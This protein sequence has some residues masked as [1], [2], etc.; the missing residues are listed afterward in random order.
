[1]H[2]D[3]LQFFGRLH[4]LWVH[5]PI[6]FVL[7]AA[8]LQVISFY[9]KSPLLGTAIDIALLTGAIAALGSV[10][11]GLFLS[12]SGG[13]NADTLSW[14][15]WIGIAVTILLFLTW[16]IRRKATSR[17]ILKI[18]LSNWLL[19]ICI[20]L[21]TIGGHLGGKMTHGDGYL[22]DNLPPFLQS[23]FGSGKKTIT[24]KAIAELDSV[25]VY[26]D[27]I[28]PIF[29]KHCISCHNTDKKKGE[30]ILSDKE[31]IRQGGKSGNTIVAGNIEKSELFHRITLSPNNS[32]FMPAGSNNPLT[33]VEVFLIRDWINSGADYEKN[34]TTAGLDE[35][36]KFLVAAYLGIDTEKGKEIKLPAAPA[37]DSTVLT[38]LRNAGLIIKAL[39]T[40]S[41]LLEVSFVM[42]QQR[43]QTEIISLLGKLQAIKQ[44][45]YRL[46]LSNCNLS[47]ESIKIISGFTALN[48]LELQKTNL[49]DGATA[50]LS[51]LQQLETV[52]AGQNSLTD[53]SIAAFKKMA[54][55]KK[56][57]LWQT[58]ISDAGYKDLQS[59]NNGLVIER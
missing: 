20:L 3:W 56:I 55:L 35:K 2:T 19:I 14:H 46:D 47:A 32:K 11:S 39:A 8:V 6:G 43:S 10:L 54:G 23:L 17:A 49:T 29:D 5:L 36:T 37:V 41:N 45:V 18:S 33:P 9:K 4:P 34:I 15:K 28:Q 30:L 53:N 1:M 27:I 21:I 26:A 40:G 42:Q 38:E 22:T 16:L 31:N 57:N 52:N 12:Q 58:Q 44:Q 13:Y 7:F 48:K 59:G 25:R 51:N 24:K 50:I